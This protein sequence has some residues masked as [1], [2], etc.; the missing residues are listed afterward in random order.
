MGD[1]ETEL[2]CW[3]LEALVKESESDHVKSILHCRS[4]TKVLSRC[5]H[6]TLSCHIVCPKLEN[7]Y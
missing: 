5:G 3:L 7:A 4:T 2:A 6:A 1:P